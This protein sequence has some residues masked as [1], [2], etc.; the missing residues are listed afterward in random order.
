MTDSNTTFARPMPRFKLTI[1]IALVIV[2]AIAAF[3][4]VV[5]AHSIRTLMHENQVLYEHAV[6]QISGL[7]HPVINKLSNQFIDA[8]QDGVADTPA[9]PAKLIDPPTLRFSFVATDTPETYRDVFKDFIAHLSKQIGRPVEYAMF[10]ST[11]DEL[12]A[13]RD[14]KLQIAGFNTGNVPT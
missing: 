3:V 2:A 9:D 8:N 14:G 4:Y 13:L 5:S 11:D 6:M 7:E 12:R 10:T 1:V